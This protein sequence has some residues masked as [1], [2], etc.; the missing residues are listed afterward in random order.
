[1]KVALRSGA[2]IS[3]PSS[4]TAK[5]QLGRSFRCRSTFSPARCVSS[6]SEL[7]QLLDINGM[8][9]RATSAQQNCQW[10]CGV[11]YQHTLANTSKQQF[12][13]VEMFQVC[14][15]SKLFLGCGSETSQLWGETMCCKCLSSL[16]IACSCGTIPGIKPRVYRES[17][18][19]ET[20]G[21]TCRGAFLC[22]QMSS[23][24][25]TSSVTLPTG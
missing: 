2:Q 16:E 9:L 11:Y 1:M 8:L 7:P 10:D 25:C 12:Q 15:S 20:N 3:I 21:F 19:L 13:C 4:F 5:P 22:V 24:Q 18:Q 17:L 23:M 6:T 14:T